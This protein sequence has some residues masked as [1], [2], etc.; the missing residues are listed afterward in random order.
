MLSYNCDQANGTCEVPIPTEV[1]HPRQLYF[2]SAPV[3]AGP[4]MRV[5]IGRLHHHVGV[6]FTVRAA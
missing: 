6:S 4:G 1:C 5:N 2:R 3:T